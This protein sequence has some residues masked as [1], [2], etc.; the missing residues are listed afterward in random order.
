MSVYDTLP[1]ASIRFHGDMYKR[2]NTAAVVVID[3]K[4]VAYLP[5]TGITAEHPMSGMP[6]VS[7]GLIAGTLDADTAKNRA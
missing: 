5:I 7:L 6:R 2:D 4:D 1:E 3:G